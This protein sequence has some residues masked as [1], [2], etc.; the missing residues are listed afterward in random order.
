VEASSD[1][2]RILFG[3]GQNAVRGDCLV[4][5]KCDEGIIIPARLSDYIILGGH[6]EEKFYC[7]FSIRVAKAVEV[8]ESG[9]F[10]HF[11]PGGV[12][13]C[14]I[15]REPVQECPCAKGQIP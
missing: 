13:L 7:V 5:N 9:H 1:Y 4:C 14:S 2:S 15:R 6:D 12:D 8:V 3:M 11:S 10:G